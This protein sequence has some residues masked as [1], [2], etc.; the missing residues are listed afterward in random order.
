M[1]L[2]APIDPSGNQMSLLE[3]QRKSERLTREVEDTAERIRMKE[4]V[5]ESLLT[6]DMTLLEAASWFRSLHHD[7]RTWHHPQRPRPEHDDA[8]AWCRE[9][10]EWTDCKVRFEQ[11]PSRAEAVCQRLEN[12]LRQ[13]RQRS[14][15]LRLL[16]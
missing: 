12:E 14:G 8:E 6:G 10:I 7:A 5:V 9:V 16:D 15:G 11:S 3:S 4:T 13:Q 1:E 2:C